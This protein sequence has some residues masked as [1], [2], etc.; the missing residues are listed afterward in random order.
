MVPRLALFLALAICGQ[1]A[2]GA[3]NRLRNGGFEEGLRAWEKR[4][5]DDAARRLAALPE[6][7]RSGQ[8][9]LLLE[10]YNGTLT[11]LR[12]GQT[13]DLVIAPGSIVEY[14]AWIR[15][16]LSSGTAAVRFYCMGENNRIVSESA[17]VSQ[18]GLAEWQQLRLCIRVPAQTRYCMAYLEL[19][20]AVG[21][22][23]FDDAELRLAAGPP[24]PRV[25]P[26][27]LV[28]TDLAEDAPLLAELAVLLGEGRLVRRGPPEPGDL[29]GAAGCIVVFRTPDL[30]GWLRTALDSARQRALPVVMD[31]G[32]FATLHGLD[33]V[34]ARE[35]PA[36]PSAAG[37]GT[38]PARTAGRAGL[39]VQ[40][41]DPAVRGFRPGQ[42]IPWHADNGSLRCLQAGAAV[43]GMAVVA[44]GPKGLPGLV[45]TGALV[46]VDLLSPGEPHCRN[47]GAYYKLLPVAN[48]LTNPVA[49]GE[50]Y[51]RRYPYAEFVDLM[52]QAAEACPRLRFEDE[53]AGSG[54][55]HLF[56]LNL[57]RPG[58]PLY[59]LYGACH[60]S[61]WEP[62]YGL[63]TFAKRLGAGDLADVV[64]LD[65]V[66]V[67]ILPILNPAGYDA[68]S[69]RNA[70]GVDLNRQGDEA[71]STYA[72]TGP[73]GEAYGPGRQDWKGSASF[74]EPE[75]V[76]YRR[77]CQLPNLF[78]V[79]DF[80]GNSSA[81]NNKLGVL[82]IT[83][84]ADNALLGLRLQDTVNARL[85]GRFILRQ[86]D[87][88]SP[89]PYLLE[90]VYPDSR[91]PTLINTSCRD[92]YGILVEITAGYRTGY[93]TLLQTDVTAEICRAL[94][95]VYAPP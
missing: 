3:E 36:P 38:V 68:F 12:Q 46:A 15:T 22:A 24:A 57:G 88:D 25:R 35:A 2:R 6:A 58:A 62:A 61:E 19:R 4:T 34:T 45:R 33:C 75:A 48:L 14:C 31:I 73:K 7:A 81:T 60:G 67:K 20:D 42:S 79:L 37:T 92:R 85:E 49:F 50:Y 89:S 84:R 1:G 28:L 87:E 44:V 56:S 9:G 23:S 94:F 16:E 52:R 72:P 77:L 8:C 76:V 11:R 80:H 54:D 86:A 82:P 26:R 5:P 53:G 83:A 64:D 90:R 21:K 95:Q 55:R 63:L 32:S 51:E 91:R 17:M 78:C 29:V 65:R 41:A 69:R 59:L 70:N 47:P 40:A 71:W 93:G 74:V 43:P 18:P 27:V 30:P 10:N 13:Q 39:C 66:A